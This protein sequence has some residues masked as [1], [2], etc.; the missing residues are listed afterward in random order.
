M[1]Y[2]LSQRVKTEIEQSSELMGSLRVYVDECE[3]YAG[4][5]THLGTGTS[6]KHF[7]LGQLST[8]LWLATRENVI[9]EEGNWQRFICE[10]YGGRLDSLVREGK[11]TSS[12]CI[13]VVVHPPDEDFDPRYF[14]ILD[15]F[16]RGGS[17][18]FQPAPS[19]REWG[20]LDGKRIYYD[21]NDLF[22]KTTL[23][24]M[25]DE[26]MIHLR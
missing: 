9:M 3:D 22:H 26:S 5:L 24:Y 19:E 2:N 10:N 20:T 15:D 8:G 7:R 23:K 13:G 12:V 21:F 4:P 16:T 1:V 17:S 11:R 25:A 14:L 6:N 18:D